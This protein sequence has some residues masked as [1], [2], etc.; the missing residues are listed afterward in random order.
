[1]LTIYAHNILSALTKGERLYYLTHIFLIVLIIE[2]QFFG[3]SIKQ[4]ANLTM[5]IL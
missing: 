3:L 2:L 5:K 1:M 4:I